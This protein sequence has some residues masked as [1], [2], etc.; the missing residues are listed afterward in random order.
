MIRNSTLLL[1]FLSALS[2]SRAEE[3]TPPSNIRITYSEKSFDISWDTV[4][5]TVGYNIYTGDTPHQPRHRK[6]RI[7]RKLITSGA[8]FTYL[9]HFENGEKVR[10]IKGYTHYLAVTAVFEIKN[11]FRESMLSEEKN[12]CYFDGFDNM[13]TRT[14]MLSILRDTQEAPLLPVIKYSNSKEALVQFMIGPGKVLLRL[15][16]KHIDFREVGA[17][18]PISTVLVKLLRDYGI[19]AFRIDGNFI[20]EY[21]TFVIVNVDGV[22]YILDFTADQFV[23]G[24]IPVVVPRDYCHLDTQGKLAREGVPVY[25]IAKVFSADQIEL[26]NDSSAIQYKNIYT[27]VRNAGK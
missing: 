26:S 20:T 10:K 8:R 11:G 17:C 18:A 14:R 16:K 15:I 4:P 19:Q 27:G 2:V 24:V 7:N 22:E 6:K 21:H 12:N 9:W 3:I 1:L 23:P 5:G 13:T 25:T